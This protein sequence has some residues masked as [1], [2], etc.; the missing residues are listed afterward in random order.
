MKYSKIGI[1]IILI[2]FMINITSA[3][4][5]TC[6]VTE[7]ENKI[8]EL[9]NKIDQLQ[10]EISNLKV[11]NAKLSNENGKLY[12]KVLELE[13]WDARAIMRNLSIFQVTPQ[14]YK[15]D[16][17]FH[18]G[19]L[20]GVTVYQYVGPWQGD[21]GKWR[22]YK[23]IAFFKGTRLQTGYQKPG[24]VLKPVWGFENETIV[25]HSLSDII[26]IEN[27]YNNL[28]GL[29]VYLKWI[30]D[31]YYKSTRYDTVRI[32][33]IIGISVLFGM[34]F[35]EIKRPIRIIVDRIN[36]R[37]MTDFG[38][39]KVSKKFIVLYTMIA[40]II[41]LIT[42]ANTYDM[43]LTLLIIIILLLIFIFVYRIMR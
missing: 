35:G 13:R 6:N 36:M 40:L 33:S 14:G 18:M 31:N 39:R 24:L 10:K 2:I 11:E 32:I 9:N 25:I 1:F 34:V 22:Q 8:K 21:A 42:Y 43:F 37:V 20:G 38:E 7:Y 29:S 17:I 19:G 41:T 27:K 26:R 16:L 5:V 15:Y 3:N 12:N 4:N 23:Q 28:Y 30:R